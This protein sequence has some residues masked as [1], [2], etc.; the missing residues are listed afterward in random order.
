MFFQPIELTTASRPSLLPE[1]SLL[2]VQDGVGLYDGKS[3]ISEYQNGQAYLTSHRVCY[4]DNDQPRTKAVAIDLKDVE[5]CELYVCT[6]MKD[7]PY[8]R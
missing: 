2:F 3:K 4:I 7:E 5:R 8:W 6:V 1:E